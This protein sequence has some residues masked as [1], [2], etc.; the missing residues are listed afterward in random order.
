LNVLLDFAESDTE[1]RL[2]QSDFEHFWVSNRR[3]T[4]LSK[5]CNPQVSDLKIMRLRVLP[6]SVIKVKV[7]VGITHCNLEVASL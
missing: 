3:G 2:L 1:T 7:A 6:F 5:N 4:L